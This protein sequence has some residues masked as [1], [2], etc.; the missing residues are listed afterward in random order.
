M[1]IEFLEKEDLIGCC[2]LPCLVFC[3]EME[4]R[5]MSRDAACGLY[6]IGI[7]RRPSQE[8]NR[9]KENEST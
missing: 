1:E 5:C 8:D 3:L 2:G 7:R 6:K 9:T 4:G